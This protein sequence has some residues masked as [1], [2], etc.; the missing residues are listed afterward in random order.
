MSDEQSYGI[1]D[2]LTRRWLALAERR[3]DHFIEL[4]RSGRWQRYYT[5]DVFRARMREAV[6][7]VEAWKACA[8]PEPEMLK[9]AS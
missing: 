4:Y 9:K 5:E 3:R 8:A 7:D 2:A 1:P 6:S